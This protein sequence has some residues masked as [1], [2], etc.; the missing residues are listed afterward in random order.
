MLGVGG[1]EAVPLVLNCKHR[2]KYL[3][4]FFG[5]KN[6]T[7]GN[8]LAVQLL[9]ICFTVDIYLYFYISTIC[10]RTT[11]DDSPLY[12]FDSGYGDHQR[13]KKLLEVCPRLI[14][15]SVI[16]LMQFFI[17]YRN[18]WLLQDYELPKFFRDDL[19]KYCGEDKRPP[20][21]WIVVGPPRFVTL[22]TT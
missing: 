11:D 9:K 8:F 20:Y 14:V 10:F 7:L 18:A 1:G 2:D 4:I 15:T 12:I 13:R 17:Y 22:K 19:F 21:R 16:C 3:N 6:I 5:P